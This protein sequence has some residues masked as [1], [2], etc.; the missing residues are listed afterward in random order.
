MDTS[1]EAIHHV[2]VFLFAYDYKG[3]IVEAVPIKLLCILYL[4]RT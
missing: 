2:A 4:S 3:F 1:S